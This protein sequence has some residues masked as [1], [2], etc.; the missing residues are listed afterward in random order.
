M[1]DQT[2]TSIKK[3][4]GIIQDKINSAEQAYRKKTGVVNQVTNNGRADEAAAA[5]DENSH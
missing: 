2:Q 3:N 1:T 4:I 5:G